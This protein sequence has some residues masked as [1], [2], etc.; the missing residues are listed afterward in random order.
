MSSETARIKQIGIWLLPD[1]YPFG[2]LVFSPGPFQAWVTS[3]EPP[4][5]SLPHLTDPGLPATAEGSAAFHPCH[6]CG[7]LP[8]STAAETESVR[9]DVFL[10]PAAD[11]E[12]SGAMVPLTQV[13]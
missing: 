9:T 7:D 1:L 2:R 6:L 12:F 13:E 11:A 8:M 10:L 3:L 4:Q 5:D